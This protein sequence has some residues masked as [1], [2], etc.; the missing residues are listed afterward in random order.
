[1]DM[2]I[3]PH[4]ALDQLESVFKLLRKN[5]GPKL[6]IRHGLITL[7][8]NDWKFAENVPSYVRR[9]KELGFKELT[10]TQLASNRQEFF[11]FAKV[12]SRRP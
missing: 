12:F 9:L 7:K 3:A 11:V 10:L 6:K 8:L 5:F 2:N 1:M 4:E